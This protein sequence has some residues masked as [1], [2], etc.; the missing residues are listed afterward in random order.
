MNEGAIDE[1]VAALSAQEIDVSDVSLAVAPEVA[2]ALAEEGQ[3]EVLGRLIDRVFPRLLKKERL[4]EIEAI[5]FACCAANVLPITVMSRT[6]ERL[7]AR[8]HDERAAEMLS[9]LA[10]AL[11]EDQRV[12]EALGVLVD[13]LGWTP[14]KQLVERGVEILEMMFPE[15]SNLENVLRG[16]ESADG[17]ESSAA[18]RRAERA[19]RFAPGSY[20]QWI[21]FTVAQVVSTDGVTAKMRHP[22]GALETMSVDIEPPPRVVSA[23]AHEVRR[24]FDPEGLRQAWGSSPTETLM[25][26]LV[27]Q[28]G[29]INVSGL[30]GIL[31]PR[32]LDEPSF[33][34]ALATLKLDC[35]LGY[36]DRPSYDSRRRL[37]VAP[38][39][40]PPKPQ[41]PAK[42]SK[43]STSKR[44]EPAA[45][46]RVSRPSQQSSMPLKMERPVWIDLTQKPEI[47]ALVSGV[48]RE[49]DTLT[50]ELNVDLP[51]RLEEA[52]AHGDLRENAEYDAAKERLRFVQARVDQLRHWSAKLHE[53]SQVR[54]IRGKVS[55]MSVVRV[56]DV[57]SGDER[58]MRLVPAELPEP[59]PGDV[60]V[61][62]P[63]GRALL[64]H[65]VGDVVKVRLPRR[66]ERMEI[67]EVTDPDAKTA[68]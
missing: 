42:K 25:T 19:L 34:Q 47:R 59:Q 67:L 1:I 41:R 8:G 40:E 10:E 5:W 3:V 52:R 68:S 15:A 9:M 31:V 29:Y 48:E 51:V 35:G 21:D 55:A 18:L 60:S 11:S 37:F 33:E 24:L 17:P 58:V 4:D 65:E 57:V 62:T 27:E 49:I 2:E 14:S 26:L 32:I 22:S 28:G 6:A 20:L 36:A 46:R 16:L 13:A 54:L 53:L 63:Y 50:R 56:A 12:D 66:E 64:G 43:P 39:V 44:A 30:K 61:G 38:G 7:I 45:E 23:G